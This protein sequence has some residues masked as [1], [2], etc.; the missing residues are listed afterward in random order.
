MALWDIE[1]TEEAAKLGAAQ[2]SGGKKI[3]AGAYHAKPTVIKPDVAQDGTKK[4]IIK[5]QFVAGETQ[6]QIKES[7]G[8]FK[9]KHFSIGHN[10]KQVA[11][12]AKAEMLFTL[13]TLGVDVS[14]LKSEG[15][16]LDAV[17]ELMKNPPLVCY[18]VAP[19]EKD[20]KYLNWT[21]K[22][23]VSEDGES[24]TDD[25]G[26]VLGKWGLPEGTETAEKP[27]ASAEE[28]IANADGEKLPF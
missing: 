7:V 18:Y 17:E 10:K 16:L 9:I 28:A 27:A 23:R 22:G 25:K 21:L 14:A 19:Q 1:N 12:D 4:W 13:R 3:I 24:V 15:G 8:G 6:E 2:N 20:D 26:E 11:D 5:F